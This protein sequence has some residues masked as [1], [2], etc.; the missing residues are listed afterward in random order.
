MDGPAV[1]PNPG[2]LEAAGPGWQYTFSPFTIALW[3]ALGE[4][5]ADV[6]VDTYSDG[7]GI[8]LAPGP[9]DKA[10]ARVALNAVIDARWPAT[11]T[12]LKDNLGIIDM[13]YPYA[14]QAAARRG[15]EPGGSIEAQLTA[16]GISIGYGIGCNPSSGAILLK[17]DL[18]KPI[19]AEQETLAREL[20][21]PLGDKVQISITEPPVAAVGGGPLRDETASA[22]QVGKPPQDAKPAA[23]SPKAGSAGKK[24]SNGKVKNVRVRG[25]VLSAKVICPKAHKTSCKVTVRLGDRVIKRYTVSAGNSRTVKTKLSKTQLKRHRAGAKLRVVSS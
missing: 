2:V 20:L 13:P 9:L 22:P 19:T 6:W 23:S 15:L 14:E 10:A 25:R 11:A 5:W 17:V 18:S 3:N 12:L 7:W 8:G 4:Q 16:A 21:A 24:P 1:T